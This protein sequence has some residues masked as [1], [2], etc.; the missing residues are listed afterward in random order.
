MAGLGL[1]FQKSARALACTKGFASTCPCFFVLNLHKK[2]QGTV[3]GSRGGF[4]PR[5]KLRAKNV[6]FGPPSGELVVLS[7][8]QKSSQNTKT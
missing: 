5:P 6:F 4:H 2:V 8:M 7:S 1:F 3:K